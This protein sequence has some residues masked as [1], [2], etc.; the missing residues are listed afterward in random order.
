MNLIM[1]EFLWRVYNVNMQ[2]DDEIRE[3]ILKVL[4]NLRR[5]K[6][7][8]DITLDELWNKIGDVNEKDFQFNLQY[9]L[10]GGYIEFLGGQSIDIT[11]KGIDFVAPSAFSPKHS[12]VE[13]NITIENFLMNIMHEIEKA[14]IPEEEKKVLI[15][16][17]KKVVSH[18]IT[19]SII[20]NALIQYLKQLGLI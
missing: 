11:S 13:I 1:K 9:L 4:Y 16:Q 17:L 20:S 18:P 6:P 3:K 8:Y 15:E 5:E 2:Y 14:D 10:D 19:S 7:D 12:T